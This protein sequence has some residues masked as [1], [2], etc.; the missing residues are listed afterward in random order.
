M[1]R[2]HRHQKESKK[3][4]KTQISDTWGSRVRTISAP[5]NLEVRRIIKH[6][7][8]SS[9]WKLPWWVPT[10]LELGAGDPVEKAETLLGLLVAAAMDAAKLRHW[11]PRQWP[12]CWIPNIVSRAPGLIPVK[13]WFY[14]W[15]FWAFFW[16]NFLALGLGL[17]TLFSCGLDLS[18]LYM[19]FFF[20][21]NI[22]WWSVVV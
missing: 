16:M 1:R 11:N 22:G 15:F 19:N 3:L 18:L 2:I 21:L 7:R 12:Q 14:L 6:P 17:S 20:F 5:E 8:A 4:K 10:R 9:Q 13:V